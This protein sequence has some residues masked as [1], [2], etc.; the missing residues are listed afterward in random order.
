MIVR[1]VLSLLGCS[2]HSMSG[3]AIALEFLLKIALKIKIPKRW[4]IFLKKP[5]IVFNGRWVAKVFYAI[6]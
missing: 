3:L 2:L 6:L 1:Y 4:S 5:K